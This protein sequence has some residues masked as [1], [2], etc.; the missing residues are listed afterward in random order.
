MSFGMGLFLIVIASLLITPIIVFTSGRVEIKK[1]E[2]DAV[3]NRIKGLNS[4]KLEEMLHEMRE[5]NASLKVELGEI[6]E[7]LSSIDKMMKDIE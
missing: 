5:E 2:M 1:K 3:N 7:V 6:K 4:E